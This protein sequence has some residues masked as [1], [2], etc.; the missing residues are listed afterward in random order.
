MPTFDPQDLIG[1]TFLLDPEDDGSRAQ[2]RVKQIVQEIEHDN[3]DGQVERIKALISIDKGE[4]K[5]EEKNNYNKL[6]DY[7]K[8]SQLVEDNLE[9]QSQA[10]AIISHQGILSQK[11]PDYQGS[12]YNI[13]V[14]WDDGDIT[15]EPLAVI[16][17]MYPMLCATYGKKHQLLKK[18]GWKHL[19]KYVNTTK[20][21]MRMIHKALLHQGRR[22]PKFKFGY[23]VP[24]DY[25]EAMTLDK[26]NGNTLWKDAIDKEIEQLDEY[27]T[28]KDLGSA[29]WDR[30]K[31]TNAPSDHKKIRVHLVF[32]VKHDGRH[33]ARL[34]ADGHLTDDPA[35]DVYSGVV[36]LRS[37]RLT[38]FLAELN[39]LQLWGADIGN[40]YLEAVTDEKVYVV[41]GPEFGDREG[42]I[43]VIHKALYGLKSSGKRFWEKLHD[44]LTDLGFHPSK[45]DPQ[46]WMRPTSKGDAYEYI[47]VYVDDLAIAAEDCAL[48]CELLKNN[49]GFKLKGEGPLTYHLGCDFVR[50]PDGTLVASPKKYIGKI[51]SWY[52]QKYKSKPKKMN[53]PLEPNDHP[54][55]DTSDD[56]DLGKTKDVQSMVRQLQWLVSLIRFD[57]HS[58][59]VTM[60]R[61]RTSPKEGH[62]DR[63]KRIYG[64]ISEMDH[65]R[66]RFRT[67]K[68]DFSNLP[69][70]DFD[71]SRSVYGD[72][73]EMIPEDAPIP[74]GRYV[75]TT[76][77]VDAN[78]H[79][80]HVTGRSLIGIPH[81]VNSTP[82]DWFFK[83]P[84]TVE[85]TS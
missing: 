21:I 35:E 32:D 6:L 63:C 48:I 54:E 30:G 4:N 36:S 50:D 34:V 8:Y 73:E 19:R 39:D 81:F 31:V 83:K 53:T 79:H 72:V 85:S 29:Q 74:R 20:H 24:R 51:L 70:Q 13:K 28:F 67:E 46:I 49:C 80:D 61:Y 40:A 23:Q 77:Y 56:A 71:W 78:L 66:L 15:N 5:A 7:I 25:K 65:G 58:A 17:K 10:V 57:I 33:K 16:A 43:L 26:I 9:K 27:S 2:A 1:R 68:P 41:A 42:S 3:E 84:P 52:E 38:I 62:V 60:S 69:P 45:A 47:A 44:E 82:I 37:L 12:A 22:P 75:V 11:H 55:L 76:T 59:V 18:P 14:Q 64:Y